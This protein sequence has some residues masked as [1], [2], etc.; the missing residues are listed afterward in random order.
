MPDAP[1]PTHDRSNR[2]DVIRVGGVANSQQEA[3][4]NHRQQVEHG[5]L[6]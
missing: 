2:N 1:L 4:A 5:I 3:Y 6:I